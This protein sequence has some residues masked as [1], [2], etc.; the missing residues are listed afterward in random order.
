ITVNM[1]IKKL[2]LIA[3]CLSLLAPPAAPAAAAALETTERTELISETSAPLTKE[4]A[5]A[6]FPGAP[7]D[8][9]RFLVVP[10]VLIVMAGAKVWNVI[11]DNR[12]TADLDSAYAS[13][14]PGF[15]F[16]WADLKDWR[17]ITKKYRYT[18]D[19]KLQGRAVDITYEVAFF[20]GSVATP[21]TEGL[22][23][24][25]IANFTVKPLDI[26]LKWGWKVGLE[27][28]MSDPMNIGVAAEPVAWLNADLKWRY[29]KPL[30]TDPKIGMNSLSI[31]GLGALSE[32]SYKSPLNLPLPPAGEPA[33]DLPAVKWH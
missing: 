24:H 29:A 21:G 33:P 13:A 28:S 30:S 31:D 15:D 26:N 11:M 25:Y 9:G 32:I 23:G 8:D 2:P 18:I 3:L 27:V 1:T 17:K 20:H 7:G 10:A 4:E 16:N 5:Q 14:I 6:F 22:K 12:P 19:K